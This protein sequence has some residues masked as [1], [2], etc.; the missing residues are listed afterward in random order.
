LV[1]L[2]LRG[3]SWGQLS[4]L[5]IKASKRCLLLD[6]EAEYHVVTN[7]VIKACWLCQLLQELHNPLHRSTLVYFDNI[8]VVYLSTN[9]AQ[10][11]KH[12]EID[13]HFT[14]EV[15]I[16]EVHILHVPI[17]SQFA[18][19]FMKE[20]PFSLFF[21]FHFSLNIYSFII[22]CIMCGPVGSYPM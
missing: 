2:G 1:H 14:R 3:V 15:A 22:V 21:E 13:L 7:G 9:P 18:G 5:V 6:A 16:G 8:N 4:L 11:T 19:I 12:I 20:L 17:T 10:H